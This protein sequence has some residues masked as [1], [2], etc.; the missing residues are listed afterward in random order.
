MI[1][2][3]ILGRITIQEQSGAINGNPYGQGAVIHPMYKT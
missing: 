3:C 1:Y 2:V